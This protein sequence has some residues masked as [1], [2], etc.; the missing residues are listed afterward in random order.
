[1]QWYKLSGTTASD[2]GTNTIPA[3]SI[4]TDVRVEIT[5][6]LD[7]SA[8]MEIGTDA[9]ANAFV[10]S[11]SLVPGAIGYTDLKSNVLSVGGSP[12]TPKVTVGGSPTVG[13]YT[14]LIGYLPNANG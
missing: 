10:D 13:G 9:D 3:N 7:G 12:V 11:A 2:T 14:V 1:M 4:I 5:T 8:T 6:A